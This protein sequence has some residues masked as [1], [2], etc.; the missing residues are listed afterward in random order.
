MANRIT[1]AFARMEGQIANRIANG[2]TTA[3]KVRDVH[4]TLDMDLPEY[5]RFQTL[6]TLAVAQGLLTPE[7]GQSIYLCL[8]E[9]V[10]T[11]NDQPIYVKTVLTTFFAELLRAQIEQRAGQKKPRH[12]RPSAQPA[13]VSC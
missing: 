4:K 11:F 7:E 8:G 12:C 2:L 3:E 13:E 1:A 6:K 5:V 9:S 10:Q